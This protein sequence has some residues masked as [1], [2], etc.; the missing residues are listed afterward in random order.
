MRLLKKI[1][2]PLYFYIRR[3]LGLFE[4]L[5]VY[6]GDWRYFIHNAGVLGWKVDEKDKLRACMISTY[7]ILEKGLSMPN[8]R[9]AFGQH[10]LIDLIWTCHSF[11]EKYGKEDEQWKNALSVI[12]AYDILHKENNYIL[13]EEIQRQINIVLDLADVESI[14]QFKFSRDEFFS[15][16]N[17][18]FD[19]FSM[20]RHSTRHFNGKVS[21][22][23]VIKAIELAQNAPSACNE[24]PTRLHLITNESL[25]DSIMDLQQG[26]RGFGNLVDKVIVL[27][28][29]YNGCNKYSWRFS[30]FIDSGIYTMNLLYALHFYKIGAI[31]LIWLNTSDR[32]NKLRNLVG[33]PDYEVPCVIVAIGKVDVESICPSSPRDN[34]SYILKI[35]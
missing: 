10:V 15:K 6:I 17:C 20:S 18:P 7:H 30:P 16:T 28:V 21:I 29:K 19:E 5:K 9:L 31:P 4:G 22:D 32:N 1:L 14:K 13:D 2:K 8:R 12:K 25:V 23:D 34:I 27:T 33:I 11:Y 35:H 26:N 3:L 24:Q